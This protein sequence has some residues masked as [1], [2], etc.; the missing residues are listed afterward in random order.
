M[1]LAEQL[2]TALNTRVVI[3]QAKGVL[4]E[5]CGLSMHEAFDHLR[6]Y[7][8]TTRTRLGQVAERV[9]GH[10][11]SAQEILAVVAQA[12]VEHRD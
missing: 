1:L 9:V 6:G 5:R 10:E 2:Q 7:A 4:A 3:E 11:L 12:A 8:R